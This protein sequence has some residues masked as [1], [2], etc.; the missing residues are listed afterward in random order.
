MKKLI[1]LTVHYTIFRNPQTGFYSLISSTIILMMIFIIYGKIQSLNLIISLLSIFFIFILILKKRKIYNNFHF[2]KYISC[3]KE[4]Y[5]LLPH[6]EKRKFYN[7]IFKDIIDNDLSQLDKYLSTND[8]KNIIRELDFYLFDQNINSNRKKTYTYIRKIFSFKDTSIRIKSIIKNKDFKD[9]N[10]EA[11]SRIIYNNINFTPEKVIFDTKAFKKDIEKLAQGFK[12]TTLANNSNF[13][14]DKKTEEINN[15]KTNQ[16]SCID[17]KTNSY[18][19][20]VDEKIIAKLFKE[21]ERYDFIDF[22]QTNLQDFVNVLNK[23]WEIHNSK[24]VLRMDNR[25]TKYF[26]DLLKNELDIN[27]TLKDISKSKKIYNK[28]GVIKNASV[29]SSASKSPLELPKKAEEIL[30]V[31][32]KVKM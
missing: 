11:L 20:N 17:N 31:I 10:P 16:H 7:T 15:S 23:E 1:E 8:K 25:Q 9:I 22:N 6:K 32:K 13:Y 27:I 26:F 14:I 12:K 5:K 28:N 29:Y 21:L 2:I 3:S 4:A 30:Q 19:I 18:N 24:I